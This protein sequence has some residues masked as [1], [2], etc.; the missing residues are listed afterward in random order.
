MNIVRRID[1]LGRVHI[2]KE[3]RKEMK[4]NEGD[5]LSLEVRNGILTIV[6]VQENYIF[7]NEDVTNLQNRKHYYLC[8]KCIEKLESK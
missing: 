2:P 8:N 7:C 4:I 3:L 1:D 6:K 5:P